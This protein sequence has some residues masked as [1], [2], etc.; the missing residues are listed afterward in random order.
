MRNVSH[1]HFREKQ[2][3]VLYSKRFLENGAVCEIMLQIRGGQATDDN[4]I[5]RMHFACRI[6]KTTNI[7]S[8]CAIVIALP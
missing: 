4:I 1:K 2:T 5:W 7:H 3:Y 8:E 6:A